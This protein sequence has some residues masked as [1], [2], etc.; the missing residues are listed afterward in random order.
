M[1]RNLKKE[2][3]KKIFAN[4]KGLL[5]VVIVIELVVIAIVN[6]YFKTIPLIFSSLAKNDIYLTWKY[7]KIIG[8]ALGTAQILR[9]AVQYPFLGKFYAKINTNGKNV[10]YDYF[11]KVKMDK[12]DDET[13]L[14]VNL[15]TENIN[16]TIF[17]THAFFKDKTHVLFFTFYTLLKNTPKIGIVY[18][19]YTFFI[20][21]LG[22]KFVKN[23][24]ESGEK[25]SSTRVESKEF[26]NDL[27]RNF[28][29]HKLFNLNDLN[30]KYFN[31][32]IDNENHALTENIKSIKIFLL[33]VNGINLFNI[34]ALI[35]I[36]TMMNLPAVIKSQLG[37]A[38]LNGMFS[39]NGFVMSGPAITN[40]ISRITDSLKLFDLPLEMEKKELNINDIEDIK[41]N[42]I[43]YIYK[44]KNPFTKHI[45][46]EIFNNFSHEFKKGLNI[47]KGHSGSGKSTLL[48]IMI[49]L[50]ETQSGDV[51]INNNYSVKKYNFLEKV[52]Y[53]TQ[54]D[55][56]FNRTV[57]EN[58]L[59][60]HQEN[61]IYKNYIQNTKIENIINKTAGT[62]G[63]LIS[64]GEC[65]R[66]AIGRS[67]IN[68]KEGNIVIF[69]EPFVGLDDSLI[70]EIIKI[71]ISFKHNIVIIIDHTKSLEKY[72]NANKIFFSELKIN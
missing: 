12:I 11:S 2:L 1:N 18:I 56:I 8:A 50:Y 14:K 42:N 5:F 63:G 59:L 72:L 34:I 35:S 54:S 37:F 62:N 22:M 7:I 23:V 53:I 40:E 29:L 21:I 44:E 57:K 60:G 25:V 58:L 3:I 51:I 32:F 71:I 67:L 16:N 20:Y 10:A 68:Y 31:K 38:V 47:I 70:H 27:N 36:I 65:K 17:N 55:L 49:G 52:T 6:I 66:I 30:K 61:A 45:S 15:I 43:S 19:L 24:Y 69:D 41:I 9:Y 64:G 48:K 28:F 46:K 13:Y 39:L 26:T 4:T 33:T